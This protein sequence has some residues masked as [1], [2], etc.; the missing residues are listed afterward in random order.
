MPVAAENVLRVVPEELT[1]SNPNTLIPTT[2]G[3]DTQP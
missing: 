3:T 1:S 2:S